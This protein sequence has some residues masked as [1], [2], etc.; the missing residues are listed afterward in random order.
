MLAKFERKLPLGYLTR[1][2]FGTFGGVD[3]PSYMLKNFR[4]NAITEPT[5]IQSQCWPIIMSGKD[6]IGIAQTGSGKTLA[7][8][9]PAVLHTRDRSTVGFEQFKGPYG[10]IL[11][12][13]RELTIQ[14]GE[15]YK[16]FSRGSGTSSLCVYGGASRYVQSRNLEKELHTLIATPGRLIDFID[17][18]SVSLEHISY[19][20][21]DEADRMLDMGFENQLRKIIS[22]LSERRQT[23]M[24][25]ATWPKGVEAL[26]NEF[27]KSP[28]RITIGSNI[29]S[30]NPD[31]SQRFIF[32]EEEDQK[33]LKL[34]EILKRTIDEDYKVLIFTKT[35]IETENLAK[36]LTL[37]KFRAFAIHGDMDQKHRDSLMRNFR[38]GIIKILVATDVAQRGLDIKDIDLII[39]YNM[40]LVIN[41]YIHRIGRTARAGQKGSAISFIT[42]DDYDLSRDLIKVLE[43]ANQ[44]IPKELRDMASKTK[45][46]ST[47]NLRSLQINPEDKKASE[48]KKTNENTIKSEFKKTNYRKEGKENGEFPRKREYTK[49]KSSSWDNREKMYTSISFGGEKKTRNNKFFEDRDKMSSR[50]KSKGKTIASIRK[51]KNEGGNDKQNKTVE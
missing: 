15:E 51:R 22:K 32:I 23:L 20:V 24:F 44:L 21:L 38:S 4:D 39:N 30:A 16:K 11:A 14:I 12:P 28:S 36:T 10:L 8:T 9:V 40:P 41:D 45:N 42:E 47:A 35:K 5:P 46:A 13:T 1:F 2:F 50:N 19:F 37:M 3:F 43:K 6:L 7:F 18:G 34:K 31:I 33:I 48:D 26:A 49:G 29:L 27:L 25:T 17:S